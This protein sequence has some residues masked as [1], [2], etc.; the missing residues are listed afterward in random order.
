MQ[1]VRLRPYTA[2]DAERFDAMPQEPDGVDFFG[3][4]RTNAFAARYARDG[5]LGEDHGGLAIDVEGI[6]YVGDVQWF[7]LHHGPK[8]VARALNI[9]IE[10]LPEHRGRGYGTAAQRLIAEYLFAT[11]TIERLEAG[12]DAENVAEQR[13]LTKAGFVR[14]GVLRHAWF[15]AGAW[16]DQVLFSRLRGDPSPA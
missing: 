12:T 9:G 5:F 3:Y 7:A 15:R 2:D 1:E 16:H 14:E 4:R 10:L 6:G 8:G 11:T 13:A